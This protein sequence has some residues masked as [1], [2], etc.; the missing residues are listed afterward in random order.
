MSKSRIKDS[1]YILIGYVVI[2]LI[3][4]E[5]LISNFNIYS[6]FYLIAVTIFVIRY[7]LAIIVKK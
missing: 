1:K 2:A 7:F 6:L 3:I 5:S 4:L